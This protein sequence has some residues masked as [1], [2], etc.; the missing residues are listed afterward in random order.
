MVY[1]A[2]HVSRSKRGQVVGTRGGFRGCTVWLT[3][4]FGG[5]ERAAPRVT[6]AR[7]CER[8]PEDLGS[9][10]DVSVPCELGIAKRCHVRNAGT[11]CWR[12]KVFLLAAAAS[13]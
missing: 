10:G 11:R 4:I 13:N 6:P 7:V 12:S 3:G 5:R 1:Q 2:H 9:V 8:G